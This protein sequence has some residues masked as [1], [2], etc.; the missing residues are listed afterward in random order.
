[1]NKQKKTGQSLQLLICIQASYLV[2]WTFK[3]KAKENRLFSLLPSKTPLCLVIE[4]HQRQRKEKI[5]QTTQTKATEGNKTPNQPFGKCVKLFHTKV[6]FVMWKSE[7]T[8]KKKE[9]TCLLIIL[10]KF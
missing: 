9:I 3:N 6:M 5:I 2:Q 10:L 8:T 1:M 7:T 4:K